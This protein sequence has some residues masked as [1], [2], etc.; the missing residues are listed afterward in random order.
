M[1]ARVDTEGEY[2]GSHVAGIATGADKKSGYHGVA[3]DADIVFVSF[4]QNSVDIPNAV[5]YIFDY[6]ESVG[7]P[8]VINMSLG[9]HMGPH[10]GT[11]TIDRFFD[12]VVGPGRILVGAAGNE[13]GKR[14]HVHKTF[15]EDDK[16][17]KTILGFCLIYQ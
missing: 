9:S 11:S 15:T 17:L 14:L 10:D 5:K 6:A 2:H 13:G 12:S 4:G 16:T 7:K 8:C 3:P 1:S